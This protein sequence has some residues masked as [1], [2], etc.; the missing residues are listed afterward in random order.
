MPKAGK[1]PAVRFNLKSHNATEQNLETLISLVFRYH[2]KRLVYSTGEKVKPKYWDGQKAKYTKNHP[3]YVDLNQRLNSLEKLAIDIFREFD[4]GNISIADFKKELSYRSGKEE[5]PET[6]SKIP[7]YFE[8]IEQFIENRKVQT[9]AK[10]GTWKKF[11]TVF[12]HL[13]SYSEEKEKPLNYEDIDWHFKQDFENWLYSPPR[14]HAINNAAKIFQVSKQ[15]MYESH[16]L[17]YH[18][19]TI[20]QDKGFG[21]KRVKVKNKIRL[22]FEELELLLDLD[23]SNDN[24][25]ERVRDLFIVGCYTGLRFSDWCK[26]KPENIIEE[27]GIEMLELMTG[28]TKTE[29]IIPFLPELKEVLVKY[30]YQLPKI[31]IQKFNDYIKEVCKI[32]LEDRKFLRIY[33]EGGKVHDEKIEKWKKVS[34]HAAR[35]SFAT[36][37]W[38]TGIP[39]AVLMQITG[40]GSEKQ[41]FEYID[42]DKYELAK[43]FAK[44]VA[45]KQ[46]MRHLKIAK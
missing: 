37:F 45:L 41:F 10:R 23:L 5:R 20:F 8:F 43:R 3:E 24:R 27:D 31:S 1:V 17:G 15:F 26:I 13:K 38:E 28:K 12:N 36:N 29:V 32:A 9:N 40:H 22:S 21:I 14:N 30:N 46:R 18:T 11:Q 35:R 19:N 2:G 34:S 44:Q 6:K 16:R 4:F 25:L 7:T 33:S 42:V 39:A